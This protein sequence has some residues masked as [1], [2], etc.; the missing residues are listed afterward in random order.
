M[1]YLMLVGRYDSIWG[2]EAAAKPLFDLVGTAA[3]HKVMKVYDTDH[4]PPKNEYV[5]EVLSWLDI[6]LGSVRQRPEQQPP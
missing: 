6:Y 2:F 3:E 1:P 4:I 5:A